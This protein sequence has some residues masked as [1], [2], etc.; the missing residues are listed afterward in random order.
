MA[1]QKETRGVRPSRSPLLMSPADT[2][3]VV[4]DM[5]EKL[6]PTISGRDS[7]LARVKFGVESAKILGLPV[8]GTEQYPKGL[9]RTI[10]PLQSM[11]DECWA[12][13]CFSVVGEPS[14]ADRLDQPGLRKLLLLGIEAH[15]CVQQ[16]AFDLL[17]SGFHVFVAADG[18]G[19]RREED[20][21][22]ALR[23][24]ES[25]GITLTTVESAVFE[26]VEDSRHPDFKRISAMVKELTG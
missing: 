1:D 17:G 2:A 25:A 13:T 14:V 23:R 16:S 11:L 19:S 3:V 6:W 12:K 18:V 24:M 8:I 22:R 15:V 26:W 4:I 5:Q 10:A 20:R 7:L 9:G 21:E